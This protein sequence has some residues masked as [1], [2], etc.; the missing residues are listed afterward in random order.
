MNRRACLLSWLVVAFAAQRTAAAPV[1]DFPDPPFLPNVGFTV[2]IALNPPPGT[3]VVGVEELPPS[4][5]PVSSISDSGSF[6]TQTGKI[7]WGPFFAPSIP[8]SV[9][10]FIDPVGFSARCFTGT[11]SFDGQD[12]G[13]VGHL[14]TENIVPTVSAWGLAVLVSLI[15]SAGTIVLRPRL[16][17]AVPRPC[18]VQR[19]RF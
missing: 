13:I 17:R 7:K 18:R 10:Y 8:T 5:W 12:D 11:V 1:R 16:P 6:D 19:N 2:T 4:G 3:L 15:L 14:C 9:S